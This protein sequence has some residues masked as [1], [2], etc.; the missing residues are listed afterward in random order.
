MTAVAPRGLH[1]A[2]AGPRAGRRFF[3]PPVYGPAEE[4]ARFAA[5]AGRPLS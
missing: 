1:A 4:D 3:M 2:S 5:R